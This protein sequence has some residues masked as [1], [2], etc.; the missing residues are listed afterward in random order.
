MKEPGNQKVQKI[1]KTLVAVAV[2]LA[3]FSVTA[4]PTLA[5]DD[6][7]DVNLLIL[8]HEYTVD[9]Y[10]SYG[11][12][13]IQASISGD[14][15]FER[16]EL[17]DLQVKIVNK[18]VIEGFKR[19]NVNQSLI[20]ES[21][22]ELVA[23]DEMEEEKDCTIAR[24]IKASL[25]SENEYIEVEATTSIRNLEELESGHTD[26][27]RFTIRIDDDIPAGDYELKL[28]L[29][30]EYQSNVKTVTSKAINLGLAGT[31]FTKEYTKKET[32]L[33]L[34]ISIKEEPMFEVSKVSGS[35]QQ[36]ETTEVR[37]SYTNLGKTFAEDSMA[38]II[39]MSPLS[40]GKSVI[41]LGT[42]GPGESRTATFNI[43]A[44]SDAVVKNYGIDS[45]IRYIDE[46]GE[47]KFSENLKVGT[48]LEP[49][50]KKTSVLG[51]SLILIIL[52]AIYQTVNV[53]R[54]R[55]KYSDNK[56]GDDNE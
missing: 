22:E 1:I 27:L 14:P 42:I 10:R 2:L 13:E 9:Y 50:E 38:R 37:V 25:V 18:G 53:F 44:E 45:E 39:V 51:I 21:S 19:L 47:T 6:D 12:P 55:K 7:D 43:S 24:G 5:D 28:P 30:Y 54:N 40:T 31:D 56:L 36:G 34:P 8:G 15:E 41:R 48:P 46:D 49:A 32:V 23:L 26:T 35:L 52:I 3:V 33:T 4:S 16:G 17:A 11:G 29:S 20:S